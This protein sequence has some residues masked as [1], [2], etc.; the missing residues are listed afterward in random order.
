MDIFVDGEFRGTAG[1][2]DPLRLPGLPGGE[3][4]VMG[5]R[6]GYEPV[7]RLIMIAPGQ[8]VGVELR[9]LYPERRVEPEA[10]RLNERGEA[11]LR[12]RRSTVNP[13]DVWFARSQDAGDLEGARELFVEA[14]EKDPG[15]A[16]AAGNLGHVLQLLQR[17]EESRDAYE[18]VLRINPSDVDARVGL[19][20]V[21]LELGDEA[22]AMRHLTEAQRLG[23]PTHELYARMATV[24]WRAEDW[25]RTRTSARQ[26]IELDDSSFSAH[27][28]EADALRRLAADERLPTVK[29]SLFRDSRD[30]YRRFLRLTNFESSLGEKLAFHFIGFGIGRRRHADREDLFRSL[31]ATGY[32]GLCITEQELYNPLRA[33]DHCRRAIRY[34]DDSDQHAPT[35]HYLLGYVNMQLLIRYETCDYLTAAARSYRRVLDIN[36]NLAPES[37][38]AR[39]FLES[40]DAN[41]RYLGCSGA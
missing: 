32:M 5:V 12:S 15:Y 25:E 6:R 28:Y 22:A 31:R 37:D 34:L 40:Y 8:E 30:G 17:H 16:R 18:S 29:Q 20:G 3:H 41:A 26:A 2:D 13:L 14:L 10:R 9:I 27:L 4:E 7:R 33:R 19:A 24:Y 38:Q 36:P 35:A 11:L 21:L 23:E 39:V 1:G